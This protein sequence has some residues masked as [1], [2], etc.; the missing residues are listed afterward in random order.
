MDIR[1]ADQ[2]KATI[3]LVANCIKSKYYSV[4]TIYSAEDIMRDMKEE[5][6]V[7]INYLKA[8]RLR[9]KALEMLKS[10]SDESYAL[11]PSFLYV[12]KTTNPGSIVDLDTKE[13]HSFLYVFMIFDASIKD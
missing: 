3:N 1:L 8:L 2:R 13:D 4:K 11:L 7:N 5:Y 12:L 6:V 9:E 10:K